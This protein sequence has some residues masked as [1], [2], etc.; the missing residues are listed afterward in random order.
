MSGKTLDDVIILSPSSI[1]RKVD[2][3]TVTTVCPT[4]HM[5]WLDGAIAAE[6]THYDELALLLMSQ[7]CA[8]V[9]GILSILLR[10]CAG[11][12]LGAWPNAHRF[13]GSHDRQWSGAL[14][15]HWPVGEYCAKN[16]LLEFTVTITKVGAGKSWKSI[17]ETS[18]RLQTASEQV[19]AEYLIP[20]ETKTELT[21]CE[22]SANARIKTSGRLCLI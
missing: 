12:A 6:S 16:G 5:W 21:A 14:T 11:D 4:L 22:V 13:R 9:V 19:E 3:F 10:A 20:A 8:V 2:N 17:G 15:L 18:E 7:G 1:D